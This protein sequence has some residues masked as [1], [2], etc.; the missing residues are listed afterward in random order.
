[1]KLK[2]SPLRDE[3]D[4]WRM[5]EFLRQVFKLNQGKELSWHVARLDYWWCFGNPSLEHLHVQD[6][7]FLWETEEGR[8]AAVLNP[9]GRGEVYLQVHPGLRTAQLEVEM[10]AV[11]EEHLAISGQGGKRVL[12]VWADSGD[13][14]RR[15][16]LEERG[17]TR[18]DWPDHKL[19]RSI[20][21]PI[22]ITPP[23]EG[24]CVRALGDVDELPAR[25]W[26]SWKAFHPDEPDEN[27]KGW[28]WYHNIQR[29]PLYRR[30]LDL[31]AEAPDGELAAFCTVWFD[32]VTLSGVFEPVGTAPVHQRRG[33]GKAVMCEG[34]RRLKRL[35]ARMAYV[36]SY[37]AP[38]HALYAS[39]GFEQYALLEPWAKEF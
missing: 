10:I 23:A 31:I 4:Y 24:Y 1:M 18:G 27:Y 7:V 25:S 34:L 21:A 26:V 20:E 6:V 9:E 29:A 5:R 32:D 36:S 39:V 16:I 8:L 3:D 13:S 30:D 2:M 12:R 15:E 38:A 35:G 17:Y 28:D 19:R 14:L 22:A 33:L 37:A 11:A